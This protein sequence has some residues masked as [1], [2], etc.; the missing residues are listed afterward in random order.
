MEAVYLDC[1][2]RKPQLK[3]NPLGARTMTLAAPIHEAP[4]GTRVLQG[5]GLAA[6]MT[7]FR[8]VFSGE[9]V[10][11]KD[12]VLLLVVVSVGGGAGGVVYYVTDA[13][14]AGGGPL[15][16]TANVVSLLAYCA[17]TLLAVYIVYLLGGF[18]D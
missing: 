13:W 11:F 5:M 16:T 12:S 10:E 14:R 1:G 7:V 6:F 15:K 18:P 8:A 9:R 17:V 2:A 3:R 4:L